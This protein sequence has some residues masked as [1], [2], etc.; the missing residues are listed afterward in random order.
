MGQRDCGHALPG[1]ASTRTHRASA[2]PTRSCSPPA[3]ETR[4]WWRRS[5]SSAEY[6][7][8]KRKSSA[9]GSRERSAPP[10]SRPAGRSAP[11]PRRPDQPARHLD[12]R[13]LPRPLG[14]PQTDKLTAPH[15]EA[16]AGERLHAAVALAT[17]SARRPGTIARVYDQ[18]ART[19]SHR[20]DL[21]S[22][23]TP[24]QASHSSATTAPADREVMG[25]GFHRELP[26]HIAVAFSANGRRWTC[27]PPSR[28]RRRLDS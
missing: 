27:A 19:P 7:P 9:Q 5:T 3:E 26:R 20:A 25:L 17:P 18:V 12:E 23:A 11:A 6:Q 16:D 14:P 13:R 15:L 22:R 8:K 10:P 1:I 24:A 21:P 4:R 2:S 28:D